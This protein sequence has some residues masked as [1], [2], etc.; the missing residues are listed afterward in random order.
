MSTITRT[1]LSMVT[2]EEEAMT[3]EEIEELIRVEK[4]LLREEDMLQSTEWNHVQREL[5]AMELRREWMEADT[6]D[7]ASLLEYAQLVRST[8]QQDRSMDSKY[9]L[10]LQTKLNQAEARAVKVTA[11]L[12][13]MEL[14]YRGQ[15][16]QILKELKQAI[17]ELCETQ[18]NLE[19]HA[20]KLEKERRE[21]ELE[22][23]QKIEENQRAIARL[24]ADASKDKVPSPQS[25]N[26]VPKS[27][28]SEKATLDSE[29]S[30]LQEQLSHMQE[31]KMNA[32]QRINTEIL[33]T[34]ISH[35]AMDA[36]DAV[37]DLEET[38][39]I[40]SMHS[41]EDEESTTDRQ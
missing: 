38:S 31:D 39:A 25:K 17:R 13:K 5:A 8:G 30:A 19:G 23:D 27:P 37:Q 29:L 28:E 36:E 4:Q 1:A 3:L 21:V 12:G 35:L 41:I 40:L 18:G 24:Q 32:A 22:Y 11:D 15:V 7:K 2:K 14:Y 20:L 26:T 33:A 34:K 16:I 10:K 6:T 9:V